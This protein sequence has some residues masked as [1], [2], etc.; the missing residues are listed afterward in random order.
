MP[1]PE[2]DRREAERREAPRKPVAMYVERDKEGDLTYCV[3]CDDGTLWV[4][5]VGWRTGRMDWRE[6]PGAIPGSLASLRDA[7]PAGA[8]EGEG[9]R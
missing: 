6:M 4:G 8:A 3:A 7:H 9:G 1:Q 2:Q 5:A